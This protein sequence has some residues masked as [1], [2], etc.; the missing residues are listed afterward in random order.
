LTILKPATP[1]K[2]GTN[3]PGIDW[4]HFYDAVQPDSFYFHGLH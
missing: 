4:L 2:S 3:L 1:D